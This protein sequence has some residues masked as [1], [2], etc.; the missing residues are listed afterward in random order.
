VLGS[1]VKDENGG[2]KMIWGRENS[3]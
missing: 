2:E 1:R 3:T